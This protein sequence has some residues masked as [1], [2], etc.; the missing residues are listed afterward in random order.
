MKY[1]FIDES[2]DL[3]IKGSKYIV[4]SAILVENTNELNRIIKNMR[5]NKFKKELKNINE[6][7][8]YACSSEIIKKT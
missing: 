8:G 2:G 7:K 3:G 5:R 6:I 4:I 1:L